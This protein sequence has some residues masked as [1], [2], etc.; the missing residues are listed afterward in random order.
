MAINCKLYCYEKVDNTVSTVAI[1]SV[2]CN[3]HRYYAYQL[4]NKTAEFV[5]LQSILSA[6]TSYNYN[7]VYCNTLYLY[8]NADV[9][10]FFIKDGNTW[11]YESNKNKLLL[12]NIRLLLMKFDHVYINQYKQ[13]FLESICDKV[14]LG[15]D[16]F[17]SG[18]CNE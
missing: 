2:Y 1:K 18:T 10:N 9:I 17:D 8:C 12:R 14:I 11:K 7:N 4:Y 6:L 15:K 3:Y 5:K 16:T 13:T